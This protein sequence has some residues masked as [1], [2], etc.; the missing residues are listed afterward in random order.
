MADKKPST[1]TRYYVKVAYEWGKA[2]GSE[3]SAESVGTMT[4]ADLHYDQSVALQKSR[5]SRNGNS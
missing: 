5:C 2:N 1:D 4:W 3:L